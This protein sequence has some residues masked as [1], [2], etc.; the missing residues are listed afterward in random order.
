MNNKSTVRLAAVAILIL[1]T[2]SGF[3]QDS[4]T[5]VRR[6][7]AIGDVHG[8]YEQ[9][10][11]VLAM[12]DLVNERGRWSGDDSH[13]VQTGDLPDRGPDSAKII[14]FLKKLEGQAR[15]KGGYVHLLIGN[16]EAMNIYGDLRY[17][18]PGEY[19]ALTDR[20]SQRQSDRYYRAFIDK[21]KETVPVDPALVFDDAYRESWRKKYPLG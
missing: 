9:L 20:D 19:K 10:L 8:D 2:V 18:H 17:V 13:L 16:H 12:A 21:L 14:R 5:G 6:I 15:R 4:W 11:A 3:A 7:V 1:I